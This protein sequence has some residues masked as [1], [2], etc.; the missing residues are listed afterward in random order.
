MKSCKNDLVI[1]RSNWKIKYKLTNT[2]LQPTLWIYTI[3]RKE[4][5]KNI[6]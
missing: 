4:I 6:I 1:Q 2:K 5:I 3:V